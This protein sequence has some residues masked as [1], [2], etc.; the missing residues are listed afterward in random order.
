MNASSRIMPRGLAFGSP[1]VTSAGGAGHA[2]AATS[3]VSVSDSLRPSMAFC[4]LARQEPSAAPPPTA[5]K[6]M[7]HA[8]SDP[9]SVGLQIVRTL[10]PLVEPPQ[11]AKEHRRHD[12]EEEYRRA[13]RIADVVEHER[14]EP[15]GHPRA[16]ASLRPANGAA[17]RGQRRRARAAPRASGASAICARNRRSRRRGAGESQPSERLRLLSSCAPARW[18][19]DLHYATAARIARAPRRQLDRPSVASPASSG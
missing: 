11:R 8:S 13:R 9:A 4:F 1:R 2:N 12:R 16:R 19:R 15:L 5:V 7:A 6:I 18:R 14:G 10:Q 3:A 17:V